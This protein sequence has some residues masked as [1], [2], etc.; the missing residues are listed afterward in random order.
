MQLRALRRLRLVGGLF[1]G[2]L[3][4]TFL[5]GGLD[6]W[7]SFASGGPGD[8][9]RLAPLPP[10]PQLVPVRP[11]V[12]DI[13]FDGIAPPDLGARVPKEAAAGTFGAVT[14]LFSW[15]RQ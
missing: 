6:E 7:Q 2:L 15:R 14:K 1:W 4:V 10:R 12:L 9:P 5:A 13:A 11:F 3:A 8:A